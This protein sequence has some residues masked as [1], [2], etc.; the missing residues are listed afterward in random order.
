MLFIKTTIEKVYGKDFITIGK[1]YVIYQNNYWKSIWER[2]YLSK[3]LLE[4]YMGKI[5][6]IKTTTGKV[7]GKDFN[8]QNN[9]W[10]SIWERF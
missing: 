6:F 7:Y 5:L 1:V 9:D 8:Y 2:F 4:K 10:K 3:Q